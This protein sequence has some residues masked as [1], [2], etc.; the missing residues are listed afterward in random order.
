VPHKLQVYIA[1]DCPGCAQAR[2][3]VNA[4]TQNYP[5][6]KIDLL[7]LSNPDTICPDNIFATPTFVLDNR[8]IS[9]GNPSIVELR[10]QLLQAGVGD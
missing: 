7:N 9:L 3:L 1:D 5:K 10:Q 2:R 8:I 6:L 4:V